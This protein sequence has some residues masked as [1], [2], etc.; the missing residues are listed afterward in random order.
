MQTRQLSSL[1]P[2]FVLT[3]AMLNVTPAGRRHAKSNRASQTAYSEGG[4]RNR[5]LIV[6][7]SSALCLQIRHVKLARNRSGQVPRH[8]GAQMGM[9]Y[10]GGGDDDGGGSEAD[11][12][13]LIDSLGPR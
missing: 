3:V 11:I 8:T 7:A 9:L 10:I 5:R 6:I 1:A 2:F 4:S 13:R 12:E